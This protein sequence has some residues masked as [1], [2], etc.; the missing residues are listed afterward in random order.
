MTAGYKAKVETV[1][2]MVNDALA[3]PRGWLGSVWSSCSC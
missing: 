2:K 3:F 1:T